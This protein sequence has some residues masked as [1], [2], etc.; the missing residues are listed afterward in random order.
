MNKTHRVARG[1]GVIGMQTH[2]LEARRQEEAELQGS[3][4]QLRLAEQHVKLQV[5]FHLPLVGA[6]EAAA[7]HLAQHG[8]HGARWGHKHPRQR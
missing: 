1:C 8:R 3:V 2:W 6:A 7:D 5:T 4:R